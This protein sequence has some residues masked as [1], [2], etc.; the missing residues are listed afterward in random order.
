M[1][2]G[3]KKEMN[4]A[5]KWAVQGKIYYKKTGAAKSER[6]EYLRRLKEIGRIFEIYNDKEK[7]GKAWERYEE[8]LGKEERRAGTQSRSSE[9]LTHVCRYDEL[10]LE[11]Y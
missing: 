11:E 7:E 6:S 8:R 1:L 2:E 9:Y 3:T 5:D 4:E 10:E